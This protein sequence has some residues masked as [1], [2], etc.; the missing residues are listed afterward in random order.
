M[1]DQL[2]KSGGRFLEQHFQTEDSPDSRKVLEG[3]LRE[4]YGRVVYSHKTHEK[5]ADILLTKFSRIKLWQIILSAVTTAGFIAAIVGVGRLGAL[6][7]ILVS[8][9]LLHQFVH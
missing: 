9:T 1:S 3:Q 7:G 6:I 8:T 5:C 2:N 4:C